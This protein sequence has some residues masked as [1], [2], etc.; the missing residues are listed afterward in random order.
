MMKPEFNDEKLKERRREH[1]AFGGYVVEILYGAKDAEGNPTEPRE[2]EADGHGRWYGIDCNGT[3][4]MFSWTHS[5][6]EGGETELLPGRMVDFL[7]F[8]D[9]NETIVSFPPVAGSSGSAL[10]DGHGQLIGM[11]RGYTEYPGY[12]ETVAVPLNELLQY[13]ETVFKYKIHYQ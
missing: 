2:G 12:T 8:E 7:E 3:Y 5:R 13:F 9:V 11:M 10:F 1:K 4:T 6:E